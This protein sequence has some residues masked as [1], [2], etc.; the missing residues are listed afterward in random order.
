MRL[1]S[2]ELNDFRCFEKQ[3][4][5][6][7]ADVVVIYGRNGVGKTAVFD[8]IEL[9][10]VGGIGR[11][12]DEESS[13]D[14]L[15]RVW[16]DAEASVR[17]N[18]NDS[19]GEWVEVRMNRGSAQGSLQ[20]QSSW[21]DINHRDFLHNRL[22][23]PDFMPARRE[24]GIVKDLLRSTT[25]LSQDLL[26]AFVKSDPE[27]RSNLLSSIAGSALTQRRL[28]KA[29]DVH[30]EAVKQIKKV[31]ANIR[32]VS[33]DAEEVRS[34]LAEHEGR[35]SELLRQAH[36]QSS[37]REEISKAL[38]AADMILPSPQEDASPQEVAKF[39]ATARGVC[40]QKLDE[41]EVRREALAK[42]EAMSQQHAARIERRN[43]LVVMVEDSKKTLVGLLDAENAASARITQLDPSIAEKAGA[44]EAHRARL[45]ALRQLPSIRL[46]LKALDEEARAL[47]AKKAGKREAQREASEQIDKLQ[48]EIEKL[49]H[50]VLELGGES[51]L[52]G[53][54]Y[55]K[56]G[57][58]FEE[59]PSYESNLRDLAQV[60]KRISDRNSEKQALA[61]KL[62]AIQDDLSAIRPKVESMKADL[63]ARQADTEELAL[64][65]G[66]LKSY[67]KTSKCP[68]CDHDH[69]SIEAMREALAGRAEQ[70]DQAAIETSEKLQTETSEMTRLIRTEEAVRASLAQ[71]EQQEIL[72]QSEKKKLAESIRQFK[73]HA[74]SLDLLPTKEAITA[75]MG[76]LKN[77]LA[78]G[79][80]AQN[81]ADKQMRVTKSHLQAK[82]QEVQACKAGLVEIDSRQEGIANEN[83]QLLD[84][85]HKLG[86]TNDLRKEEGQIGSEAQQ[87]EEQLTAGEEELLRLRRQKTDAEQER[88]VSRSERFRLE[89]DMKEWEETLAR[90]GGEI[91]SYRAQCKAEGLPEDAPVD[92]LYQAR[93]LLDGNASRLR[94]V[95]E[96][97]SR[98]EARAK[99]TQFEEDIAEL[100]KKCTP[101]EENLQRLKNTLKGLRKAEM[102]SKRWIAPL[103]DAVDKVVEQRLR[104]HQPEIVRLFKGMIPCPYD[105][106]D[107]PIVRDDKGI[108]LGLAYHGIGRSSGEP[109]LFL[110]SAQANVLALAIF[111]SLARHQRWSQLNSILLDDPV[112]HLDDLD[113]VAFLDCLRSIS[114]ERTSSGKQ[115]IMS[116][117]NKNLYLMTIRKFSLLSR[118]GRLSFTGMSLLEGGRDGP[119][120][121]YDVGGPD[122]VEILGMT[123]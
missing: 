11:F 119:Q 48:A 5:D 14:Y 75:G 64:L 72:A 108:H 102:A 109:R 55:A 101:L 79:Q 87:L 94:S 111:L 91:D 88:E 122:N 30:K 93:K 63:S 6:L 123:G 103:A 32:E 47:A 43:G 57:A 82:T 81:E 77:R 7:S 44:A 107:V 76:G 70:Q 116:T 95:R 23:A 105:F 36:G 4:I 68:L 56:A 67:A 53:S 34:L 41:Q 26:G 114:L 42:L 92:R 40:E 51:N 49:K 19:E 104:A 21:G 120:V 16:G 8:A 9:A 61:S 52:L 71:V 118:S 89:R 59:L 37:S 38:A 18:F 115:I 17:L 54:C 112:Q 39:L 50:T 25:V 2:I 106:E 85:A 3:A 100:K 10:L 73:E 69:G 15:S 62:R 45:A 113:A 60:Q 65:L 80:R 46:S 98:S 117:C 35:M 31:Q 86:I 99:A 78:K 90:L 66:R 1:K 84:K 33:T 96:L 110:S 22:V 12:E 121:V 83:T 13:S 58:L 20:F 97:L 74:S 29:R 27:S 24:V 28:D